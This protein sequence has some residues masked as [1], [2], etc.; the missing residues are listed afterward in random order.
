MICLKIKSTYRCYIQ[1]VTDTLNRRQI[2]IIYQHSGESEKINSANE[3]KNNGTLQTL[4]LY[5]TTQN[6]Q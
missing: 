6:L 2:V 3:M 4:F 5:N 1:S